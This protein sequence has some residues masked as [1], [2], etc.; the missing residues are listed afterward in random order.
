MVGRILQPSPGITDLRIDDSSRVAEDVLNAPE[1][2][3]GEYCDLATG[4]GLSRMLIAVLAHECLLANATFFDTAI[5]DRC[6]MFPLARTARCGSRRAVVR[7]AS[8]AQ[9]PPPRIR[10]ARRR[11]CQRLRPGLAAAPGRP[12]GRYARYDR[13]SPV[14]S[15]AS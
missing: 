10:L 14:P 12:A 6:A 11:S 3:A 8:V 5:P 9:P 1:A 13:P 4:S 7:P 2:A 15:P